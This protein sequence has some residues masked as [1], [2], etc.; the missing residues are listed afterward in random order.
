MVQAPAGAGRQPLPD[1]RSGE[2]SSG[3]A[4][5]RD[6]LGVSRDRRHRPPRA[7]ECD[8]GC[9]MNLSHEGS[10]MTHSRTRDQSRTTRPMTTGSAMLMLMSI[11]A[12]MASVAH[13]AEVTRYP[14]GGGSKFPIAR[15]VEVP[16]GTTLIFHSGMTPTPADPKAPEASVAYWGDTKTQTL[17][18]FARIKESLDSLGL[19]FGDVV[20]M[21]VYLP[22]IL[23]SKGAW[24]LQDSWQCIR[25]S[26]ERPLSRICRR[27]RQCRLPGS[28]RRECSWRSR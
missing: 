15:A 22:A 20:S 24:I 16:A 13:S 28:L 11:A 27:V 23:P 26:S 10:H 8:I 9:R 3:L 18:V 1:R 6:P 25:S 21:T 14:L 4:G 12:A 5:R 17:S 2:L 7:R 19:G